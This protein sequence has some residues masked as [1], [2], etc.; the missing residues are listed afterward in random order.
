MLHV[1]TLALRCIYRGAS[2]S[3]AR[4]ERNKL[5]R[6]KI[7]MFIYPIYNHIWR[8]IGTIYI[9]GLFKK[10]PNFCYKNFIAHFT[11]F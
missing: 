3:L 9:R 1:P 5:Q 4:P 6:Q 11:T 10:R 8:N 7:L 2:K